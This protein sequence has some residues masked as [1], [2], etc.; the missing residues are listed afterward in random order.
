[1]AHHYAD[2][3]PNALACG[4]N[5]LSVSQNLSRQRTPDPITVG[6]VCKKFFAPRRIK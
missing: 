2:T 3:Q 1:M 5:R 4:P 6:K